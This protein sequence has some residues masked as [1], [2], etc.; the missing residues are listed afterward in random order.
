MAH[1]VGVTEEFL[2]WLADHCVPSMHSAGMHGMID[3]LPGA[4]GV[5]ELARLEDERLRKEKAKKLGRDPELVADAPP[6]WRRL[7][8]GTWDTVAKEAATA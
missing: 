1:E 7:P 4:V 8:D 6:G 3:A 5:A 2:R